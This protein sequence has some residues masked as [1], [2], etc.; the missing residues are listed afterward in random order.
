MA[1]F[2]SPQEAENIFG[3]L[4]GFL[5]DDPVFRDRLRRQ[6]MS[7]RLVQIDPHCCFCISAD[8]FHIGE[9]VPEQATVTIRRSCDVAHSLW[10][11]KLLVPT[12][13]ATRKVRIQGQGRPGPGPRAHPAPGF[14]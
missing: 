14:R 13:I 7:V 6:D 12:A 4:F 5:R 2:I 3:N 11:G 8:E 9:S 10:L 1:L